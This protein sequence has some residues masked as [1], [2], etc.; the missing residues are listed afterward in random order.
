MHRVFDALQIA[1]VPNIEP[2]LLKLI[3]ISGLILV[4]H[5]ILL[6]LISGKNANLSDI[7]IQKT[8]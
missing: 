7:R 8:V 5:I 3:G 1:D 4:P 2:D 6:F